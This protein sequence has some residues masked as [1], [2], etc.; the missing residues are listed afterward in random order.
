MLSTLSGTSSSNE[1][2][3]GGGGGSGAERPPSQEQLK[4]VIMSRAA[5]RTKSRKPPSESRPAEPETIGLAPR[6]Q[7]FVAPPIRVLIVEDNLINRNIMIRFL[8][9]MNVLFDVAANGEEAVNM[10]TRAAEET[11]VSET[12]AAVAGR[13]PYHIIFMDIQMPI[14]DGITATKLIRGL[15][16]QKRIGVWVSTGSVASMA[17]DRTV[18]ESNS[19]SLPQGNTAPATALRTVR[20]TP[21]HSKGLSL[22]RQGATNP[23][24]AQSMPAI[25][26]G[27]EV[28]ER[29][30]PLQ[31]ASVK[32]NR[33]LQH[34]SSV[35]ELRLAGKASESSSALPSDPATG[36]AT[37]ET[38]AAAASG[39]DSLISPDTYD[40]D[41]VKQ[42]AVFPNSVLRDSSTAAGEAAAAVADGQRRRQ[43]MSTRLQLPQ[44][45]LAAKG[46]MDEEYMRSVILSNAST[47]PS[48][49]HIKSPV[50]I[51]AL[52]ASSL[53]SDRRAALAAGCNDFLTKP[54]SLTW[55]KNKV[56][57]WG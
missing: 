14:M 18:P 17:V 7:A 45:V 28:G 47:S 53:Q 52:T 20:W 21:F 2:A 1:P 39:L 51:V 26:V 22:I 48:S 34:I 42:F 8:R 29:L 54:V 5:T 15:E 40:T 27:H 55:L 41:A 56:M 44:R 24:P 3:N 12:G 46:I 6:T 23:L 11:R 30:P 33:L 57:E 50:I 9:H 10:W 19:P 31:P 4:S 25:V 49:V 13:G 35:P 16:R 43:L 37:Y 38:A 36:V 32:K